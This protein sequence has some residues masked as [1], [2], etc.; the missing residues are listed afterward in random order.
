[1][2]DLMLNLLGWMAEDESK[3][4]SERVK[5]SIRFKD[6]KTLS[7]K[8]NK[9]GRKSLPLQAKNKIISLHNQGLSMRTIVAL[10]QT[11]DKN[12]NMK[13]VSLGTVHKVLAEFKGKNS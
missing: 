7:Y 9:W 11:A 1:M 6:G 12:N 13:N 8:G 4:K 10:V 2:I 3:K 5:A